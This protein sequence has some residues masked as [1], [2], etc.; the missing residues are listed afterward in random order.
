MTDKESFWT[1][2]YP[3]CSEAAERAGIGQGVAMGSL[4]TVWAASSVAAPIAAGVLAQHDA[5]AVAY[6]AIAAFGAI[7]LR[8]LR[9][10]RLAPA[11]GTA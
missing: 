9:Q 10:R 11:R 1:T 8:V 3:L 5:A 2:V 6:L 7:C 4:N